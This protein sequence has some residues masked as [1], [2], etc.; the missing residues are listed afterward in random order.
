[1]GQTRSIVR[2]C[3]IFEEMGS[4]SHLFPL[5]LA[6]VGI[7]GRPDRI[8]PASVRPGPRHSRKASLAVGRRILTRWSGFL[9]LLSDR[10]GSNP[11]F[12]VMAADG[13][14]SVSAEFTLP[15]SP[16]DVR[17]W[18]SLSYTPRKYLE[19]WRKTFRTVAADFPNEYISLSLGFG[20][21]INDQG[22]LDAAARRRTKQEAID[23][24]MRIVGPRF[25]L[26][27]SNLDGNHG[28]DIGPPGTE[29]KNKPT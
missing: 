17:T 5:L 21:N 8:I 15:S 19:A 26:Q 3:R 9:K 16:E 23:A 2:R 24:G 12:R 29:R 4:A 6:I 18:L 25:A 13:P 27:Y 14:T 22:R 10:Y 1:M 11:A 20:L 28:P 7:A